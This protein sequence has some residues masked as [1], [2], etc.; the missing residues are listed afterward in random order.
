MWEQHIAHV[1]LCYY[2]YLMSSRVSWPMRSYVTITCFKKGVKSVCLI[3]ELMVCFFFC[4]TKWILKLSQVTY[5]KGNKW[6]II[7]KFETRNELWSVILKTLCVVL[8]FFIK[9]CRNSNI[10]LLLSRTV[11]LSLFPHSLPCFQSSLSPL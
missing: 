6:K 2:L 8:T 9:L 7:Q 5:Q 1:R 4:S 11:P 3:N 10:Y